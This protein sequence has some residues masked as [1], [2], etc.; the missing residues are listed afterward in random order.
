MPSKFTLKNTCISSSK[1]NHLETLNFWKA[2]DSNNN[3]QQL[4][5]SYFIT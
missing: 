5:I 1:Q 3:N 4:Y 2:N